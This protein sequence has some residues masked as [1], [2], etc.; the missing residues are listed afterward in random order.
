[1]MWQ[2]ESMYMPILYGVRAMCVTQANTRGVG[3][4]PY[5]G[6]LRASPLDQQR[7]VG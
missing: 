2:W 5:I 3:T 1:L 4:P 6:G 7:T